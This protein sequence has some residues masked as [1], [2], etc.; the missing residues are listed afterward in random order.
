MLITFIMM[1]A[2]MPIVSAVWLVVML[3]AIVL[4]IVFAVVLAKVFV[5]E[6]VMPSDINAEVPVTD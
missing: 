5:A 2:M 6:L 1:V 4:V 3:S